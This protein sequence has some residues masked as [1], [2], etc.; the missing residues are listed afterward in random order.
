MHATGRN[1]H[2]LKN[3]IKPTVA[4]FCVRAVLSRRHAIGICGCLRA[5]GVRAHPD[6]IPSLQF[7]L[8]AEV[9]RAPVAAPLASC[10]VSLI[11][12]VNVAAPCVLRDR[13]LRRIDASTVGNFGCQGATALWVGNGCRGKF[14]CNGRVLWCA[15]DPFLNPNDTRVCSCKESALDDRKL[16]R[17]KRCA[18]LGRPRTCHQQ[19]GKPRAHKPTAA[20]IE[21]AHAM[22]LTGTCGDTFQPASNTTPCDPRYGSGTWGGVPSLD[23][24]VSLCRR[25]PFCNFISC[26]LRYDDCTYYSAC[27]LPL[28]RWHGGSSYQ[29]VTVR[30]VSFINA[31][32]QNP[33]EDGGR[34]PLQPRHRSSY[35][36]P[37]RI[38]PTRR[39]IM[40]R[41]RRAVGS[42]L[43]IACLLAIHREHTNGHGARARHM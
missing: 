4:C 8:I 38:S 12:S 33:E 3:F 6:R 43:P 15:A 22:P 10:N 9:A 17:A 16:A 42:Q 28:R 18:A 14:R 31:V 5:C 26:S 35:Y 37:A 19:P 7:E 30:S 32:Y 1:P 24:C 11:R 40:V 34:A 29:T 20:T 36:S 39:A 13:P 25:C 27:E 21:A 41:P 2:R 23:S